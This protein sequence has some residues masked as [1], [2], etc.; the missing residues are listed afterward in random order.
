MDALLVVLVLLGGV[1]LLA[2]F[3]LARVLL[4]ARP[5]AEAPPAVLIERRA[6]VTLDVGPADPADPAA[7]RLVHE[8][9]AR[10][11]AAIPDAEE[12]EVRARDGSVLGRTTRVVPESRP[13]SL[14]EYLHEPHRPRHRGPDLAGRQAEEER[15]APPARQAG[16]AGTAVPVEP[17]PGERRPFAERFEL[18]PAIRDGV[19]DPNDPVDVVRAIF[20]AAG[21]AVRVDGDLLRVEDLAIAVVP[22]EGGA[23][24][25]L[26][27]AYRW[28]RAAGPG[29]G[30]VVALGAVDPDEV[31]RREML[32][33]SVLHTGLSGV[34]RM[35]D[36]VALG[37][38]PVRFAVAPA[39]AP[40]SLPAER[41]PPRRQSR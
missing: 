20:A 26:N 4:P 5:P 14:P 34:Q 29:R 12:V 10:V 30:L 35:A 6:V 13:I 27:R 7:E 23:R 19:R 21:L 39:L 38:D 40:A 11:F 37:A 22:V 28:I 24:D 17:A 16:E 33:P 8:A 31:R 41:R 1:L 3:A 36:A 32:D 25:T 2:L 15:L 9:A 18:P